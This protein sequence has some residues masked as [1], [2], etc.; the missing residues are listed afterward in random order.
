[1]S[2][3]LV[4]RANVIT[5][6]STRPAI[7]EPTAA[8]KTTGPSCSVSQ[9]TAPTAAVSSTSRTVRVT[10]SSTV[11]IRLVAIGGTLHPHFY[12]PP[13]LTNNPPRPAPPL[14]RSSPLGLLLT[15][16]PP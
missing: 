8:T 11:I 12:T 15:P 1:M 3:G 2:S 5:R 16:L 10:T 9:D 13:F 14:G 6:P 4:I 7:D